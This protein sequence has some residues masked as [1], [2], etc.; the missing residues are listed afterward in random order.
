[1][2]L[3]IHNFETA[4]GL[5]LEN[6]FYKVGTI[7]WDLQTNAIYAVLYLYTSQEAQE[8]GK[9]FFPTETISYNFTVSN[10]EIDDLENA[11]YDS[12]LNIIHTYTTVEAAIAAYEADENNYEII[13][14]ED[15]ETEIGEQLIPNDELYAQ[16]IMLPSGLEKLLT[17]VKAN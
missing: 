12:I 10:D 14:D 15:G 5:T 6:G 7:S 9:A 8:N 11:C 2:G 1:M 17:A 16:R 13:F 3:L 4:Q